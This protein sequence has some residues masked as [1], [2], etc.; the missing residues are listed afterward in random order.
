MPTRYIKESICTSDD[1]EAL[2]YFERDMFV[3]LIVTVDDFGRMDARPAIIKGRMF[4]LDRNATEEMISDGLL[5]MSELG[6]VQIYSVSGK[7]Y[8][9]LT[10]WSNHQKIRAEKSKCPGPEE[11][12]DESK[13]SADAFVQLQTV[14][15]NC[16]QNPANAPDN[17]YSIF[18]IRKAKN[19]T[20][21]AC[22]RAT[23]AVVPDVVP[24]IT[25]ADPPSPY[26]LVIP[27]AERVQRAEEQ[28]AI[29]DAAMAV[30]L[31]FHAKNR[32]EAEVLAAEYTASWLIE[33]ISRVSDSPPEAHSWRYVK[34]ILR[35]WRD[36][37]GIDN[38]TRQRSPPNQAYPENPIDPE[39]PY[40]DW[41]SEAE[42]RLERAR[43]EEEAEKK[44]VAA[45]V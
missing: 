16:P 40:A 14:A 26:S 10:S 36:K 20:V 18:D 15:D 2:T 37:G 4:P 17:R 43:Q 44:R 24:V 39:D 27:D 3:R 33:S 21:S 29:E 38:K 1:Y 7:R 45:S 8:L 6:L 31:P 5:H 34:G 42:A 12:E 22:V 19:E 28:Q 13:P 35:N 41:R 25:S 23:A 32:A 30:G 11:S 9:L